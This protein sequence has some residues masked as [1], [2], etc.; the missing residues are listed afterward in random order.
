MKTVV[1][2]LMMLMFVL[3]AASVMY[4]AGEVSPGTVFMPDGE[5]RITFGGEFRFRG[6]FAHNLTDQLDGKYYKAGMKQV[7][8]DH[9]AYYDSH[10]KLNIGVKTGKEVEGLLEIESGTDKVD[11]WRWGT[12][13]GDTGLYPN[14][15]TKR[16]GVRVRQAWLLYRTHLYGVQVGHQLWYIG[17]RL[18]FNHK[19]FGDD[20]IRVIV[21]PSK[22]V[23]IEVSTIKLAEQGI[24]HPDDADAYIAELKYTTGGLKAG[25]DVTYINDQGF[26]ALFADYSHGHIWNF[27]LRADYKVGQVMLRGDIELQAGKLDGVLN[28]DDATVKGWAGLAAIDYKTVAGG[29]PVT[30]TL[31]TAYGSGKSTQDDSKD[32][33]TFITLLGVEPHYTFVYDYYLKTAAGKTS[34][35]IAN[36]FYIK[37]GAIANFVKDLDG[38]LYVY[39]LKAAKK[40]A[41]NGADPSTDLGVEI[42]GKLTYRMSK[43]LI[44]YIE[45]GYMFTDK[46]YDT[47]TSTLPTRETHHS[48]AYALRNRIQLNF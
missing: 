16:G 8:D 29:L 46:A 24:N 48:D 14:G 34:T 22:E 21:N 4:A 12:G 19:K 2:P 31:E 41:L 30:L 11:G 33:K 20:G 38:E 10:V 42:D 32:F 27:G 43:N 7:Q 5:T 36:T 45:G 40:I 15:N 3:G 23:N 39:T 18:F 17:N 37:G 13:P 9:N 28:V 25:A 1:L 35:G 26:S 44:Y 6:M 47:I